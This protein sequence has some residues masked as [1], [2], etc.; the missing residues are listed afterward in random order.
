MPF[1]IKN[2][3][4]GGIVVKVKIVNKSLA[5]ARRGKLYYWT[6]PVMTPGLPGDLVWWTKTR[7][8]N[9]PQDGNRF[10]SGQCRPIRIGCTALNSL[11]SS[12]SLVFTQRSSPINIL[13]VSSHFPLV[14]TS[15]YFLITIP[16]LYKEKK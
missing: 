12:R 16:P 10:D 15:F 11:L 4:I 9:V 13:G 1:R 6:R 8:V 5:Q 7:W 2:S 3:S 14:P